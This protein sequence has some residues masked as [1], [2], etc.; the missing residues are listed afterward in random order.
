MHYPL[1]FAGFLALVFTS[2]NLLPIGQLD[3]GH[4]YMVW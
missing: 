2:L 3:G 4:I 1:L